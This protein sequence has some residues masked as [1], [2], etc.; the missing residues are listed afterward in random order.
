MIGRA[1]PAS[2]RAGRRSGRAGEVTW[3]IILPGHAS[4]V[5]PVHRRSRLLEADRH[6]GP[7]PLAGRRFK[8]R[9]SIHDD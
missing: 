7:S 5:V 2:C 8:C 3:V 4:P 1:G 9:H 6:P